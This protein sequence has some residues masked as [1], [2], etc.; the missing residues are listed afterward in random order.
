M[1]SLIRELV[2]MFRE[3]SNVLSIPCI[4]FGALNCFFGYKIFKIMCGIKGFFTGAILGMIIGLFSLNGGVTVLCALIGGIIGAVLAYAAYLLSVFLSCFG[5]GV[6][7]GTVLMIASGN[8]SGVVLGAVMCGLLFGVLGVL[9]TKTLITLQT[10]IEGALWIGIGFSLL[11]YNVTFALAVM[12]VFCVLG[13]V[14]QSRNGGGKA[15]V[16]PSQ[17]DQG[18][19][20]VP[21]TSAPVPQEAA[22]SVVQGVI[23]NVAQEIQ[24]TLQEAAQREPH[25]RKKDI[26]DMAQNTQRVVKETASTLW[27]MLKMAKDGRGKFID[28]A[29]AQEKKAEAKIEKGILRLQKNIENVW[30]YFENNKK[31]FFPM[32]CVMLVVAS[33][34]AIIK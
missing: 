10:A 15:T 33:V 32:M 13:L 3:I 6:L 34:I 9:L 26:Q 4:I 24:S 11:T 7:L 30:D 5:T 27:E 14:I 22:Q 1:D 17:A 2:S 8:S 16:L 28:I 31:A 20:I 29:A 19:I 23:Q 21:E 12:V 18:N 25:D